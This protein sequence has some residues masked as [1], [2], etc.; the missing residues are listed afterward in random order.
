MIAAPRIA[1]LP[2]ACV[3]VAMIAAA[4]GGP[5]STPS[6]PSPSCSYSVAQPATSFGP[7][8]G[9][10]TATVTAA[11]GCGWTA[12][13][14]A[15]FVTITQGASVSG[16]GVAQFTVT[17]NTGAART[18]TLTIAGTTIT[19]TQSAAVST[20]ATLSAPSA[21]SPIAG[22]TLDPGRPT[23]VVNNA[24]ATGSVGSV[25]Y[26]FE[27]SDLP[28]FPNDPIRTFTEDGIAQGSGTTSW[29]VNRDLGPSVL[30]Y[31]RA[32]ATNGTVTSPFSAVETFRTASPCAY[33][34]SPSAAASGAGGGTSTV[35]VTTA[36]TC[37]WTA[38]SN[39]AFISVTSGSSSA[40]NGTVTF[41]VAPN[42]GAA[43]TGTLTIAAQTVT[44][45]QSAAA[46]TGVIA[47]FQL[48]DPSAQGGATAECR[49]RSSTGAS[50]T[51]TLRSTSFTL[52]P[53]V[54]VMWAWTV[55]YTYGDVRTIT[56]NGTDPNLSFTDVCGKST[57]TADGAAQ[58]LLV[59][60]T[61]TDSA[62]ATATAISGSGSQPPLQVRLFSCGS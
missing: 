25:T 17:A 15:A 1:L 28:T 26:R 9:T 57:S 11:S 14:N 37:S 31:W 21:K 30:W 24:T 39:D 7:E 3:L 50:T 53:T 55:Q 51:C 27:I 20:Q 38:V 45:T 61:V 6:S 22:V 29:V 46:P 58:P 42:A 35:T 19:V 36:S 44:V 12:A 41:A 33:V 56:Q 52:G 43:R 59:T 4:C 32:L 23:I 8:G 40:G 34:V 5:S 49:F 13:S 48:V 54:V 10:G 2:M 16:N 60:L 18:A 62:G 47:S